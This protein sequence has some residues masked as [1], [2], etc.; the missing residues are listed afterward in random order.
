MLGAFGAH[1][2]AL[3]SGSL[4]DP[5]LPRLPLFPKRPEQFQQFLPLM[6]L[7]GFVPFHPS[8]KRLPG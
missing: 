5:L 1:G 2:I 4:P 3:F 6:H 8:G 7:A